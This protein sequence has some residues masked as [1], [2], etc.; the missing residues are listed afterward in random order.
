M[1]SIRTAAVITAVCLVGTVP[2]RTSAQGA[3]APAVEAQH[4]HSQPSPAG[5]DQMPAMRQM[6][7]DIKA[8][9]A[10]LDALLKDLGAANGDARIAL[11][12]KIVT[13]LVQQQKT[14]HQHMA[15]MHGQM[16]PMMMGRG[17]MMKKD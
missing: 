17:G 3:Q 15:A 9:D 4:D 11:L 6:M 8:A 1:K 7:A 16:M 5:A 12:T 2:V 10:R 14:M 13:E